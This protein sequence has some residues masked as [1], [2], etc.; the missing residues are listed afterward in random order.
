MIVALN[1]TGSE[2]FALSGAEFN[3]VTPWTTSAELALIAGEPVAISEG[4]FSAV[5]PTPSITSF[6]GSNNDL[7]A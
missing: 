6:V 3:S 7:G 1:E 5:L 4:H 2:D